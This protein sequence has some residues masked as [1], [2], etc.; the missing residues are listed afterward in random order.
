MHLLHRFNLKQLQVA[1]LHV[2]KVYNA[3]LE[4]DCAVHEEDVRDLLD[5]LVE[6]EVSIH[7]LLVQYRLHLVLAEQIWIR[8][9]HGEVEGFFG[10]LFVGGTRIIS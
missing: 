8:L 5:V 6:I 3:V 7:I 9:A 4:L 1:L 2:E 10:Q